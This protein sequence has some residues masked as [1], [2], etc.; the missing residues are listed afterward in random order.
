MNIDMLTAKYVELRDRKAQIEKDAEEAKK[1]VNALMDAIEMKIKEELHAQ[2]ATSIKTPHGTAYI[3]YRESATVADWDS[4]LTY[5]QREEK[6]D[7]LERRVSKT[8]VKAVMEED[9]NGQYQNPPPPGVSFTRFET[10][11]VRRS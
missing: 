9:R 10:V 8:A 4:L 6:W 11:N 3:A 7:L 1:P 5:I 2:Q